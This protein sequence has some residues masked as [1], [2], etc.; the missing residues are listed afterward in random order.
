MERLGIKTAF[1]FDQHFSQFGTVDVV[2]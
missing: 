1:S 2:P